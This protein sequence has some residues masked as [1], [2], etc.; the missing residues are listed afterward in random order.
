VP[1]LSRLVKKATKKKRPEPASSSTAASAA[2]GP[3]TPIAGLAT[4]TRAARRS[5]EPD[6]DHEADHEAT[7][8]EDE[9]ALGV[10]DDT[11]TELG[12]ILEIIKTNPVWKDF[13]EEFGEDV[14]R[15][16]IEAQNWA[17]RGNDIIDSDG[18]V[19]DLKLVRRLLEEH[20]S[21]SRGHGSKAG[22]KGND[23]AGAKTDQGAA[24][25]TQ[26]GAD[27]TTSTP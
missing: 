19:V 22:G 24:L 21:G 2:A 3:T 9:Q 12:E 23:K 18:N 11:V 13:A 8:H 17:R 25:N 14:V 16:L 26:A 15:A 5:I 20:V 10:A 6:A 27:T 4:A 1:I 7:E